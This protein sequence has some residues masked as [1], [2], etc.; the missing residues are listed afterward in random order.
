MGSSGSKESK[1]EKEA[2]L[3]FNPRYIAWDENGNLRY[4]T[5]NYIYSWFDILPDQ[6]LITL[7]LVHPV[8]RSDQLKEILK[9][10]LVDDEVIFSR[11]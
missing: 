4:G 7:G 8:K 3:V 6:Y 10:D 9:R 1:E 11:F 5:T 2:D